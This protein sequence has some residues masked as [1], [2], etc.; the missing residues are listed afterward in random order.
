MNKKLKN[1][2]TRFNARYCVDTRPHVGNSKRIIV[3]TLDA[4]DDVTTASNI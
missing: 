1:K 3:G 2:I 4:Q